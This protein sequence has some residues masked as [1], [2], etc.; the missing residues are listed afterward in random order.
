[1]GR[2]ECYGGENILRI[3]SKVYKHN[4][5][6]LLLSLL[7]L[8][9]KRAWLIFLHL[10]GFSRGSGG[11]LKTCTHTKR[12]GSNK[13]VQTGFVIIGLWAFFNDFFLATC[14]CH[15][16]YWKKSK[17]SLPLTRIFM[18]WDVLQR[19]RLQPRL[20]RNDM[21]ALL[22][23]KMS[24]V[25]KKSICAELL[26]HSRSNIGLTTKLQW[27]VLLGVWLQANCISYTSI[28]FHFCF[29]FCL[30]ETKIKMNP[31]CTYICASILCKQMR[32]ILCAKQNVMFFSP[33]LKEYL[34]PAHIGRNAAYCQELYVAKR[35]INANTKNKMQ[36]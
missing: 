36:F 26:L 2:L 31:N 12:R 23:H 1:M 13:N 5:L 25:A 20:Y 35:E 7:L 9:L 29:V 6:L 11:G 3:L 19:I 15:C 21:A 18:I 33:S 30:I 8:L 34:H 16:C 10:M 24:R 4:T 17:M 27:R 22:A 28:F 14:W 32:R